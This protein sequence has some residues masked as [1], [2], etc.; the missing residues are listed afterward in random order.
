MKFR[1]ILFLIFYTLVSTNL[2]ADEI[3][4]I[5]DHIKILENRNIIKSINTTAEIKKKKLSLRGN[6]SIYNKKKGEIFLDGDV[7]F[8]DAV[9]NIKIITE[10]A[11]Y[12]NNTNILSTIGDTKIEYENKYEVLSKNMIYDKNSQ[13]IFSKNETKIKDTEGN[14]YTINRYY[15]FSRCRHSF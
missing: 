7:N 1:L 2:D 6:N 13:K 12:N 11:T 5:S 15:S 8:I 9:E 14:V 10:S 3:E 4:I